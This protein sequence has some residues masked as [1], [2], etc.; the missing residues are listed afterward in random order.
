MEQHLICGR[1]DE[2]VLAVAKAVDHGLLDL[3]WMDRCP[4]LVPL[5][6]LPAFQ[7]AW[8]TVSARAAAARVGLDAD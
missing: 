5:R 4:L 2:A 6:G 8:R 7:A 3:E 1:T